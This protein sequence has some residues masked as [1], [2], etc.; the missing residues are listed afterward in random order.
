[1][2]SAD[3]QPSPAASS[4]VSEPDP[5]T[6]STP[7]G[8]ATEGPQPCLACRSTGQVISNLGGEA[9]QVACPWCAGT[10]A[11]PAEPIDAQGPWREESEGKTPPPAA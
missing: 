4:E 11:R 8:P 10:G 7:E 5:G 9:A 6:Q 3:E 1:V 2:A